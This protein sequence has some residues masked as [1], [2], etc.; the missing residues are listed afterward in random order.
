MS[1]GQIVSGFRINPVLIVI[2]DHG[3]SCAFA[4]YTSQGIAAT[5]STTRLRG[6]VALVEGYKA[7]SIKVETLSWPL[8]Y[9]KQVFASDASQEPIQLVADWED[10]AII[11]ADRAAIVVK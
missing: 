11:R 9:R 6:S 3:H 4:P 8:G 7:I 10:V 1:A 5:Y 2:Q